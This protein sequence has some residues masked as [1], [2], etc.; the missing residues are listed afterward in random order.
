MRIYENARNEIF[1]ERADKSRNVVRINR[2]V[3]RYYGNV[4]IARYICIGRFLRLQLEKPIELRLL[5][6]RYQYFHR[7]RDTFGILSTVSHYIG[8]MLYI[9]PSGFLFVDTANISRRGRFRTIKSLA[10]VR[11]STPIG[12]LLAVVKRRQ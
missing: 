10:K 2:S 8:R 12:Q 1:R 3:K 5:R 9:P 11:S 4:K 7:S 6:L